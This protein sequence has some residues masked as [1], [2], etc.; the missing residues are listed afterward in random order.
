MKK[1]LCLIAGILFLILHG[2]ENP[3][4]NADVVL[5]DDRETVTYQTDGTDERTDFCRYRILTYKGLKEMR[6]MDMHYNSTYGT[7][8]I[9][10][11]EITKPDGRNIKLDPAKLAK[12]G[13]DPSQMQSRIYDPAQ[14]RLTV[15]IPQLEVGDTITVTTLRRTLKPRLPGQWSD[16]CV[17]QAEFPIVNYQYTVNAPAAKPLLATAVK[18]PVPGT[19]TS[20]R[21]TQGDRIIYRWHARNVPQALPEP[22]MPELYTCCQRV[23]VSTVGKWEDISRWYDALCTPR[24]AKVN[25]AMRRKTAELTAG[26]TTDMEKIT[27]LFQFVSQQIRYTGI[28]DEEHAPGYEP[29]DVDQTFDRRH[30]VCRDKAALL[31]AMLRLAGI[32]AY[33]TLFMSGVPKDPEVPNIYFNHAIVA[34]EADGKYVLMDPTFETTRELFPSYLAGDSFLV[35]KPDGDTIHTAPP[36]KAESN[37]LTIATTAELAADGKLTGKIKLDFTGIYDQMYR[38]AFSEWTPDKVRDFFS[39]K[40][41]NILPDAELKSLQIIPANVRDMSV[42]LAV[43]ADFEY[44]SPESGYLSLPRLSHTLGLLEMVYSATS[45]KRRQFPLLAM[46]RAVRESITVKL[47]ENLSVTALPENFSTAKSGII[48]IS[49]SRQITNG[50]FT[51]N[52]FFAIDAMKIPPADYPA[53]KAILGAAK[54]AAGVLPLV[55]KKPDFKTADSILLDY[56]CHYHLLDKRNWDMTLYF[57]RKILNYAGVDAHSEVRVAYIDKVDEVEI[58]GTVTSPDGKVQTLSAK[59]LNRMDAPGAAAMPRYARRKIAVA[60]FPNVVA[61]STIECK[62]V[63]K[64]RNKTHF[65]TTFCFQNYT[66]AAMRQVSFSGDKNLTIL[67]HGDLPVTMTEQADKKIYTA[68]DVPALPQ[69]SSAPELS[70]FAPMLT[71]F[72]PVP[73][74]E[75]KTALEQQVSAATTAEITALAQKITA[76]KSGLE[77][78]DALRKYVSL[79][80]RS[81][82][83]PLEVSTFSAPQTTL[84]DGYGS[85]AD[86]AILL[87]AL[88]KAVNIK[89]AFAL[90]TDRDIPANSARPW[91]RYSQVLIILPDYPGVYLNDLNLHAVLGSRNNPD[92]K[93]LGAAPVPPVCPDHA[94]IK[95]DIKISSD[96]SAELLLKYHFSGNEF[97]REYERFANFTPEMRKRHFESLAHAISPAAEI[98]AADAVF[99]A[100]PGVVTLKLRIPDF[101]VKVGRYYCFKLPEYAEFLVLPGAA[102]DRQLPLQLQRNSR[103]HTYTITVPAN[104]KLVRNRRT[105]GNFSVDSNNTV[106]IEQKLTSQFEITTD[107]AAQR[108]ICRRIN[109][110]DSRNVLFITE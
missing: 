61:G 13:I 91:H 28:T 97:N 11:L 82:Y 84:A 47:P 101:A 89:Y 104:W 88:L 56:R 68:S 53:L 51:E 36:V 54:N 73:L 64:S 16:I 48:R 34:A 70:D 100:H 41:R 31:V 86:R 24:L 3:F 55:Q 8:E 87:A 25:A 19:L 108:R 14:K 37:L 35:A 18:D 103:R 90:A 81:V 39:R 43:I 74:N 63:K 15:T 99:T 17:L 75:I 71:A 33:P 27:A 7:L 42:P 32:Q 57:K 76:G 29:H 62:I 44:T 21:E 1:F 106:L 60:S 26:K 22:A 102:S 2:A 23:L 59:E 94:A 66:P 67:T 10:Q 110:P 72:T 79:H 46:P 52:N 105:F 5:L 12:S 96:G 107:T 95:C 93:L 83:Y 30:G 49:S 40:L 69:E 98:L 78:A 45:L 50:T 77:A 6:T 109:S 65:F 58:S 85:S 4:P 9:T 38:A 92:R 80:I 20:S